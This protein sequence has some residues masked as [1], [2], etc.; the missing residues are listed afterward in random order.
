MKFRSIGRAAIHHQK[1]PER[2]K[3]P[4]PL[5]PFAPSRLRARFQSPSA[6][7][8]RR[9]CFKTYRACH[10]SPALSPILNG[11]EGDGRDARSGSRSR[12]FP[13]AWWRK[14]HVH[15]VNHVQNLPFPLVPF[16]GFAASRE[17]PVPS[18]THSP[19]A[20]PFGDHPPF[21]PFPRT[22]RGGEPI[23]R[24]PVVLPTGY[25]PAPLRGCPEKP[26]LPTANCQLP[27]ATRPTHPPKAKPIPRIHQKSCPSCASCPKPA[28]SPCPPS[29]LRGFARGSCPK[30]YAP[31]EGQIQ[32]LPGF[33][34]ALTPST[35]LLTSG[36]RPTGA[37]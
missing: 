5:A 33:Y 26:A 3:T 14:N 15:H 9:P 31:L 7:T 29:R 36:F 20:K 8:H 19:K 4:L 11:G 24:R 28:F 25:H 1:T 12:R 34:A 35:P 30:S 18:L 37:G 10:L 23:C 2:I 27:T 32:P 16:R 21:Q 13:S 6:R 17:A 22:L